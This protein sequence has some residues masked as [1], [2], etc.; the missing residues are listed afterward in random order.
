LR[1]VEEIFER[2]PDF[3]CGIVACSNADNKGENQT[4][5]KLL[6]EAETDIRNHFVLEGLSQNPF[7]HSWRKAYSAFR[8]DPTKFKCSS[9]ALVRRVLKGDNI[10]HINKLVDAYNYISL[11]Y[12]TPVG[13]EDLAA[14]KETICLRFADG[15]EHF[16]AL[17]GDDEEL[18]EKGE[19]VYASGKEI[20][21]RKWNWRESERTKLT[22]STENAIL[23]I[24]AL[25]PLTKEDVKKS[26][27]DLATL[28]SEY[29]NAKTVIFVLTA[30][31]NQTSW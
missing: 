26:T 5:T 12:R 7:F 28:V 24:D 10:R 25:P 4:L 16:V 18:V 8:T 19:V 9:E 20:L 31:N 13:G 1:I 21:C 27:K 15:D 29:C 2:F 14:I 23:V 30:E 6:R 17:G 11:K 22:E 3:V